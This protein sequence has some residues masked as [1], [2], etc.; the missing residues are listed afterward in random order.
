MHVSNAQGGVDRVVKSV[1]TLY[2]KRRQAC[3]A[4][5]P[6]VQYAQVSSTLL[7]CALRLQHTHWPTA[8]LQSVDCV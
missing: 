3:Y 2:D 6:I 4:G 1:T 5:I 8:S 7:V